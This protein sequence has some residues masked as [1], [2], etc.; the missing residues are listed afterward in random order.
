[1]AV[2][3]ALEARS[4]TAEDAPWLDRFAVGE[5][6]WDHEITD[7]VRHQALDDA[8]QG[9]SS[10]TLFSFP[11]LKD[12]VGFI[13]AANGSVPVGQV[14]NVVTVSAT[15]TATRIP[16]VVI[17]FMGVAR[18]YQRVGHFGQEIHFR[19]L[20]A[21][22]GQAWAAVRLLYLECW[23]ENKGGLAFWDKMGY[24][25]FHRFTKPH[26]ETGDAEYLWRLVYDRFAIAR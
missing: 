24:T 13:T 14:S 25:K 17:P 2:A 11:G 5:H 26:P 10:T 12:V 22:D 15:F 23:D 8:A 1:M 3:Y 20:E 21:L 9:L 4:L 7:F 19:L 6:W 18:Q 16:A